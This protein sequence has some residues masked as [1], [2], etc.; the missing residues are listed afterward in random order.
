MIKNTQVKFAKRPVG[1][2]DDDCFSI[3]Q[4]DI[5]EL[6]QGQIL[7]QVCWLSLDPYMR[8]RMNDVKSY[9]APMAIGDVMTGES[10]GVVI[11][12]KSGKWQVGDKI[13]AHMGWQSHI[14]ADEDDMRLMPVDTANGSLS[15]HLGVVGMP[16]RTAYFG[17]TEVGKPQAGE[18]LVVAAASGAVGSV[19][20]QIAKIKG[21]R[22]VGIAGGPDKC[23]YVK[24]E[25]KFDACIDYKAGNLAAELQAACPDG[26]DIYFENVGGD[27]TRAV[28]PLIN[29]GAR[30][31]ICGYVSNYNDED[32]TQ[33]ETPFDILKSCE[34]VPEHRFFVVT[35]WRERWVEATRLLGG[36]VQE[37]RIKYRE[38][39]GE[40]L[41]NAPE[42]FRGMLKGKNFG[43][44]LVKVSDEPQ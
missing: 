42:L 9:A 31:P 18:T 13:A 29:A 22:A 20:G 3:E 38:S 28:A 24:E 6:Q 4:S 17:L 5:P 15:A 34:P 37:G 16:G 14:V 19:V 8:G 32:I 1:E 12:S 23:R 11:Q 21:L 44:Q 10:T 26:I 30:V 35:E 7:I 33:S 39:I 36:W 25:L 2:P 27:V 41:E 40:G 43:K